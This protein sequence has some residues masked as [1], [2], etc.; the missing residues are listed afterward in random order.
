MLRWLDTFGRATVTVLEDL[1]RF[2]HILAQ[3]L[4]W[5]FRRPFDVA[6]WARQMV[7]VGWDSIPVV[8]LTTMFTGMVLALQTYRGFERFH[9][10][11]FVGSVVALSLT[12]ELAPARELAQV[13][14]VRVLGAIGVVEL[15]E[16]VNMAAM[17]DFFVRR[18]VWIRPF[19]RLAY[20][21]PPYIIQPDELSQLTSALL[22]AIQ[23]LNPEP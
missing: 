14:D 16:P 7:R 10:E 18:G 20:L 11:G 15:H 23:T 2:F 17:Q 8:F 9:A 12:R 19:G 13:A 21:M 5:T 6:E 22:E 3:S 1:G 4:M